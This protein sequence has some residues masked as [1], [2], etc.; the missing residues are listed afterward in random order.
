MFFYLYLGYVFTD[1]LRPIAFQLSVM[2]TT[3]VHVHGSQARV[4]P[5]S[6]P[7]SYTR[8][9]YRRSSLSL[10]RRHSRNR[11][12]TACRY[13]CGHH[14]RPPIHWRTFSVPVVIVLRLFYYYCLHSRF[15]RCGF[16][17]ARH[18]FIAVIAYPCGI[19]PVRTRRL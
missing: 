11:R 10:T 6:K 15:F 12:W 18:R 3:T 9:G 4:V 13:G 7:A 17:T 8:S 1:R 19:H 14:D 5:H 16:I 2:S